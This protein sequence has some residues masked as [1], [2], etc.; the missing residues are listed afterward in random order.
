MEVEG[1]K[2][3]ISLRFYWNEVAKKVSS[4]AEALSIYTKEEY[5]HVK[6]PWNETEP[7]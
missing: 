4:E 6:Q 2:I 1:G 7:L 3:L 5:N